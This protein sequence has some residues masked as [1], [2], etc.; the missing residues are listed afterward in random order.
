MEEHMNSLLERA[1]FKKDPSLLNQAVSAGT[2]ELI[3]FWDIQYKRSSP[4]I[5][6]LTF[7]GAASGNKASSQLVQETMIQWLDAQ[8]E[9]SKALTVAGY[10]LCPFW[11]AANDVNLVLVGYLLKEYE[12]AEGELLQ[13][14]IW[15]LGMAYFVLRTG[16]MA[17]TIKALFVKTPTQNL[18]IKSRDY[19]EGVLNEPKV[20]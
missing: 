11:G 6:Q 15:A 19:L 20:Q 7:A 10:F 9:R 14:L 18:S 5:E 16:D 1:Y 2:P 8:P 4:D 17:T 3:L 12:Q 13:A